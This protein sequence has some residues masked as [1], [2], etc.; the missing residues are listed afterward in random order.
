MHVLRIPDWGKL[1]H[2]KTRSA[3]WVKSYRTDLMHETD[4]GR[5]YLGL[6][7]AARG[8]L[9]DLQRLAVETAN[10]TPLDLNYIR[11]KLN[12]QE[13]IHGLLDDLLAI[14]RLQVAPNAISPAIKLES[15]SAITNASGG[16]ISVSRS[17]VKSSADPV[18]SR[19]SLPLRERETA[20][21]SRAT[22]NRTNGASGEMLAS[23]VDR[24]INPTTPEAS[25][26]TP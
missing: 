19:R 7:L 8:L 6:C 5:G 3:P 24:V 15:I 14:E 11:W 13:E 10:A 16:L 17:A 9:S 18:V 21:V 22:T 20:D 12:I 1:Q 4:A 25:S 23:I 26:D 2:Y